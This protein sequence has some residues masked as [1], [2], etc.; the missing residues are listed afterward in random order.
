[1]ILDVT[2]DDL[3][4]CDILLYHGYSTT[5]RLIQWFDGSVYSHSS[6]FNGIVVTEAVPDGVVQRSVAV[7]ME[8][9]EYVDV[10]RLRKKGVF[11]GSPELPVEPVLEVIERYAALKDR[12]AYEGI[13]L[14]A[15]L[16]TTRRLPLPFLRGI[17]DSAASVIADMLDEGRQPMICSELV[18]RCFAEASPAYRPRIRGVDLKARIEKKFGTAGTFLSR[19]V[20]PADTAALD[21]LRLYVGAR[22][23]PSERVLP[24][25]L[26]E[27]E[28]DF[29]TPKDLKKSPDLVKIGR[30][31][32]P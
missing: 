11:V 16:C 4:P 20:T 9:T 1:M 17:L 28:A 31:I 10:Y 6:V 24:K 25:A 2:V 3:R 18:Y 8:H 14:L 29:V 23:L 13:L 27:P 5:S 12:Y 30:L 32:R 15:L 21:F 7:S 22:N 19:S 26:G